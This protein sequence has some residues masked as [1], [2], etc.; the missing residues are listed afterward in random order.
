MAEDDAGPR[1]DLQIKQGAAL[2]LG[3]GADLRLRE[4][5]IVDLTA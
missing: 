2:V 5:D 1:L 3:E 4:V